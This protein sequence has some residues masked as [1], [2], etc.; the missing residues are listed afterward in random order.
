MLEVCVCVFQFVR[1]GGGVAV[2]GGVTG[3]VGGSLGGGVSDEL[4]AVLLELC[5]Q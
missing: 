1:G 4:D 2:G 5:P 3:W